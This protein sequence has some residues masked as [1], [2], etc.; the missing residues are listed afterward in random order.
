MPDAFLERMRK[1]PARKVPGN[2]NKDT[3]FGTS[4]SRNEGTAL[5]SAH[6]APAVALF[7]APHAPPVGRN[8]QGPK[9]HKQPE[10]LAHPEDRKGRPEEREKERGQSHERK[11]R[12]AEFCDGRKGP[13][14]IKNICQTHVIGPLIFNGGISSAAFARRTPPRKSVRG[15]SPVLTNI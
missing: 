9:N 11:G 5:A 7:P 4:L 2:S 8:A 12:N 3:H 13:S 1:T 10:R 6:G 14:R 15:I